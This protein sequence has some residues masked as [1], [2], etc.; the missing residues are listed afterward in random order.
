[1]VKQT[2]DSI[3]IVHMMPVG[4][5]LFLTPKQQLTAKDREGEHGCKQSM[6]PNI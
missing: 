1:M 5:T 4:F 6:F 2:R 3:H